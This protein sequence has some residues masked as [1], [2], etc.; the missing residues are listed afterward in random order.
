MN[1]HFAFK[2]VFTLDSVVVYV[3]L[4]SSDRFL[5]Y[6]IM[7]FPFRVNAFVMLLE[8]YSTLVLVA[9]FFS[10]CHCLEGIFRWLHVALLKF[11]S[12]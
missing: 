5:A 12:L 1:D 6:E 10:V 8:L 9:D 7:P 4:Q 3:P 11:L 2:S